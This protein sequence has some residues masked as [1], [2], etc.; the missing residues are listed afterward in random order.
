MICGYGGIGRHAGFRFLWETVQVRV[1]LSAPLYLYGKRVPYFELIQISKGRRI[2]NPV[3]IRSGA[4]TVSGEEL[5]YM[6][7]LKMSDVFEKAMKRL[8]S[9]SQETCFFA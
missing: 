7:P 8:R 1:L 9:M 3:K 2:G 4:A 5:S 6:V